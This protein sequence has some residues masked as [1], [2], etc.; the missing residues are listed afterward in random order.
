MQHRLSVESTWSCWVA[1]DGDAIIGHIW[2]QLIEK[3]PNPVEEAEWHA[4][5]TNLFV[6]PG[7]RS[8]GVGGALLDA[9]VGFAR[10]R[11]VH[12]VILWPTERSRSLYERLGFAVRDDVMELLLQ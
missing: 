9:A 7:A 11:S 8:S 5:I 10:E 12:A 3:I 1:L 6:T 4:Y 2:L